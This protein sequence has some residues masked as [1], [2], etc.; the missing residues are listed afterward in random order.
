MVLAEDTRHQ[1]FVRKYLYRLG[2]KQHEIEFEPPPS[3][4]GSGEQWVRLRY[5][6]TVLAYRAQTKR[7]TTALIVLIDADRIGV[8]SRRK[9]FQDS[10]REGKVGA[11]SDDEPVVHLVPKRNIET[12]ILCLTGTD[13]DEET[14]Y[15]HRPSIDGQ[16]ALAARAFFEGSRSN[17]KPPNHWIASLLS[18]IPEVQRLK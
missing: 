6:R 10:L 13:V 17:T 12:W 16:I 8:A 3:G 9:Q 5:A 7:V 15:H 4:K 14:D 1:R 11:C 2:Y 18:A